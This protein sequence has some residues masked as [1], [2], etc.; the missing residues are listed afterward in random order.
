MTALCTHLSSIYYQPCEQSGQSRRIKCALNKATCLSACEKC[1]KFAVRQFWQQP[2][3]TV[4]AVDYNEN[5]NAI[6][7]EPA[8]R[9]KTWEPD[10]TQRQSA[11]PVSIPFGAVKKGCGSCGGRKNYTQ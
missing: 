11:P 6:T 10:Y 9:R 1:D 5:D 8:V 3:Q 2:P 4:A 7:P